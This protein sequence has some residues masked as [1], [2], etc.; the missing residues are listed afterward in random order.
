MNSLQ[1]KPTLILLTSIRAK[2]NLEE[3]FYHY[4]Q[5]IELNNLDDEARI[6]FELLKKI[7][8]QQKT[9]IQMVKIIKKMI[10]IKMGR[11]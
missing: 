4:K 10:M 3:S 11:K 6:N 2:N 7:L 8:D 5:A 1:A 9:K